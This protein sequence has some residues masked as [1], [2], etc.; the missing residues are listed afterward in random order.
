M[1]DSFPSTICVRGDLRPLNSLETRAATLAVR[2]FRA[3]MAIAAYFDLDM[4]QMDGVNAFCNSQMDEEIY[5]GLPEGAKELGLLPTTHP[6]LALRLM[7]A[8]YGLCHSPI[9]WFNEFSNACKELGLEP[10]PE[11][12]CLFTNGC[13]FLFSYVDDIAT[14]SRRE[15]YFTL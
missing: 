11:E 14:L 4:V 6:G 1:M 5:V 10:I 2:T 15:G 9:L 12:A 3:L 7:R 8:L 13:I